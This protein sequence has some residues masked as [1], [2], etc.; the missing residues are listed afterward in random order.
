M[1]GSLGILAVCTISVLAGAPLEFSPELVSGGEKAPLQLR[2]RSIIAARPQVAPSGKGT[3]IMCYRSTNMGRTWEAYS[4]MAE[5]N[6][7]RIQMGDGHPMMLAN[8]T[9]L[10]S[11]RR[12]RFAGLLTGEKAFSIQVAVSR[13]QGKSWTHHSTVASAAG[14]DSGLWSSYLLEKADGT[15][16]CYY[17]DEQTPASKGFPRH[18]WASMKT[19]NPRF[20]KW[21]NRVTVSRAPGDKLSRDGMC[22]VAQTS[23]GRLVCVCEGVQEAPPHRGCLWVVDSADGGKTWSGRRKLYEPKETDFNALAPWMVRLANGLLVVVFTTDEDRDRPGVPSTGR[24]HQSLKYVTSTD[25]GKTW[26]GPWVIDDQIPDYFPGACV[27]RDTAHSE[28]LLVQYFGRS[29]YRCRLGSLT[30]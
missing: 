4:T 14:T 10:Y 17:D 27:V 2:D 12:N 1:T 11:Y 6:D 16:Q 3:C 13:D 5:D 30:K 22:T 21:E 23:P 26:A 7:R 9:V 28:K 29:R 20:M 25:G 15:L 8:G 19:W 24:L 18:Q